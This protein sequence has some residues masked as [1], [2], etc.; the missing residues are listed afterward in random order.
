MTVVLGIRLAC[1]RCTVGWTY[2]TENKTGIRAARRRAKRFRWTWIR[3][4]DK[5][6]DLCPECS[7]NRHIASQSDRQTGG[8]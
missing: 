4:V 7:H 2:L 3:E 6:L 8:G 5:M 1:D